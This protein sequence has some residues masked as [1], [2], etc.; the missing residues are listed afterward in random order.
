[1][2]T[3][4]SPY[5]FQSS[6]K[7]EPKP[8]YHP[9][10]GPVPEEQPIIKRLGNVGISLIAVVLIVIILSLSYSR[11]ITPPQVTVTPPPRVIT[12][13]SYNISSCTSITSRGVYY[14]R[15][16]I[17]TSNTNGPCINIESNNVALMGE[18]K[19]ITGSGPYIQSPP[20]S[21]GVEVNGARIANVT[22]SNVTIL[23]FSYDIYL[24][25]ATN[26]KVINATTLNSTMSGIYL[27]NSSG[28][29][30]QGSKSYGS[31]SLQGGIGLTL[32]GKNRIIND[33]VTENA[34]YGLTINS[35][36]NTFLNDTVVQNPVDLSCGI[37]SNLRNADEF[38][39]SRCNV[40]DYCNFAYCT[41]TNLP[42]NIDSIVLSSPVNS[43]GLINASGVYQMYSSLNLSTYVN[44]TNPASTKACIKITAP[45]VRLECNN[46]TIYN[47]GYGVYASGDYNATLV[48]CN[49]YNSTYGIY[50]ANSFSDGVSGGKV[51]KSEYGLYLANETSTTISGINYS[52]N[53]YGVYINGS[54]GLVFSK[55]RVE[56]NT[57][58]IYYSNGTTNSFF[59]GTYVS[60]S[61]ADLYC[62]V[63]TYS[64]SFDIVKGNQCGLTD[65]SWASTC[66]SHFL[67]PLPTY[68]ILG[69]RTISVPGSYALGSALLSN[70]GGNCITVN[71]SNVNLNCAGHPVQGVG[72]GNAFF[73]TNSSNVTLRNCMING[74]NTGVNSINTK[75]FD[76]NNVMIY[77]TST[78]F[79]LVNGTYSHV[80]NVI[81]GSFGAYGF[82]FSGVNNGVLVNN[83]A[84][85]GFNKATGF[86]FS[87]S[88]KNVIIG[89]GAASNPSGFEFSNS[90]SNLVENNSAFSNTN[91]DYQCVG[92]SSGIYAENGLVN[93]G[94]TKSNC[95]WMVELNPLIS[96]QCYA[97]STSSTITLQQDLLY[98]YGR[99][100]Y[101]VYNTN[102]TSAINTEIN[103]EGHTVVATAGGIFAD[104]VNATGVTVE[105]CYLRG[106]TD[107][108]ESTAASTK[109][110]N[111]TI[112]SSNSSITLS[113]SSSTVANNFMINDSNGIYDQNSRFGITIKNN[114]MK[115]VNTAME[116]SG[117]T[118]S[119]IINN[120]ANG[121]K[122]G[123]YLINSQ[124]DTVQGNKLLNESQAG[125]SCS[126]L[127]VNVSSDNLDKGGN[128]C[129]SN[130]M[131]V[132]M[133]SSSQC[134]T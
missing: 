64:P 52:Q 110:I 40:N 109:I 100:C 4:N 2:G 43:C 87:R 62:S 25:N 131:C 118:F 121:G 90:I 86:L 50:L 115:N 9:E 81:A 36:G 103:C 95:F 35:S 108:I 102:S 120:T 29:T 133:T 18:G 74:Y 47:S 79:S 97:I 91:Y 105:N 24:G 114:V 51:T 37:N 130:N 122:V 32:G 134:A 16:D 63:Q 39:G 30:I 93:Q 129:S 15:S 22:I 92:V 111:N 69:C 75:F 106:F 28:A 60:N 83:T 78:A 127:S 107:A 84:N 7:S 53:T 80:S 49:F 128:I 1:M 56:N 99:T 113:N 71:V 125:I 101:S 55:N 116:I 66:T 94:L 38:A 112:Y 10:T 82:L 21:F 48:N 73:I 59:N 42:Y 98:T 27:Y 19:K 34:Y 26:S 104:I 77:N 96:S 3:E 57:Y 76:V 58:G 85:N 14:L 117:G 67:P 72:L 44:T 17:N 70:A 124:S 45:N 13:L 12:V 123:F 46:N 11:F 5:D 89:N 31:S 6:N 132:W 61:K 23:K 68:P 54:S 20:F 65:C 126:Q 88:N 33:L 8:A 119:S 41:Q